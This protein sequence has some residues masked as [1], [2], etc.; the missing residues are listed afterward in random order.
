MLVDTGN[1]N[2]VLD[3]AVAKKLGLA[4][5]PVNGKDGKPVPGYGHAVLPE[6]KIG[7][8]ALGDIKV[9][10][11]DLAEDMKRDR[12]PLSDGTIAYTAFKDR[13]LQLDYVGRQVRFSDA[14]MAEIPC[15][16]T[17]GVLTLPTFGKQG[18]PIVVAT[19]FTV[20]QKPITAQVDTLFSGTLLV[21]PTSVEKLGLSHAALSQKKRF[22]PYTDDGVNI[23]EASASTEAFGERMLAKDAPLYFAGPAVHL[24]DGMFDATVGHEL[25]A[26]SVLTLNFHDMRVWME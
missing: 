12:I 14:L 18:P 17:C 25:F 16:V 20:N 4:V 10:V 15:P 2:S 13:I 19:G 5:A 21:Y 1:V 23:L 9:L 26:H 24:P 22:F 6:A 8:G 3:T 11:M 7:D